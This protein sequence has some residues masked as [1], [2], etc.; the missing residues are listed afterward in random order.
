MILLAAVHIPEQT[1]KPPLREFL[2][3]PNLAR[4]FDLAGAA[5]MIPSVVMLLLALTFGG[6]T[7]PWSSPTTIG[8]F[9]G[10]GLT[11][12]LFLTWEHLCARDDAMLPLRMFASRVVAASA[13]LNVCVFT[14]TFVAAYFLPVYFQSVQGVAP[15][16]SGVHLLPSVISQILAAVLSGIAVGKMGYYLP[17]AVAGTA[18]MSV[19][20]GLVTTWS[21]TTGRG[22]W[23]GCQVVLGAG[24]GSVMQMGLLAVQAVLPGSQ[25]AVAM[26]V[27][28][29]VQGLGV[30]VFMTVANT[31]FDNSVVEEIL[32]RAPGVDPR[33]VLGAGATTFRDVVPT[34]QLSSVLEAWAV[35]VDNVFYMVVGLSVLAF[36]AAWSLGWHDVRKKQVPQ[37]PQEVSSGE[38]KRAESTEVN[39]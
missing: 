26:A 3:T 1:P 13:V 34:D 8:L 21:A 39:V 14:C 31:I 9:C 18:L 16:T 33:V 19:G 29:F 22:V 27:L 11:A 6:S 20:A 23:I 28:G 2:R 12:A 30:A 5:L 4:K 25:I 36:V 38:K 7:H 17:W 24:R 32:A 35:G 37:M 15:L 10:G